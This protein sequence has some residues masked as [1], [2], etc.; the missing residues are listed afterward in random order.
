MLEE[1]H[2]NSKNLFKERIKELIVYQKND[3][4]KKAI[5]IFLS[6]KYEE[7]QYYMFEIYPEFSLNEDPNA[8]LLMSNINIRLNQ[9]DS[10]YDYIRQ[11]I[12]MLKKENYLVYDSLSIIYFLRKDY[13]SAIRTIQELSI[14]NYYYYYHLGLYNQ[15]A[16]FDKMNNSFDDNNI[17]LI[18]NKGTKEEI[19]GYYESAL[20]INANSFKVLLNIGS[21]FASE[22]NFAKAE[23]YFKRALKVN[24]NDWRINLNLAFLNTEKQE[25]LTALDFF[26]KV[27]ALLK[28]KIE[29]RI[30]EPYMFCLYKEKCWQKLEEI[31]KKILKIN[32]KHKRALVLLVEALKYNKKYRQLSNLFDKVKMKMKKVKKD[33]K[34]RTQLFNTHYE[35][36]L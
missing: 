22:E 17:R 31:C 18:E 2:Y 14:T 10:A 30:L 25:Y 23:N 21:I 1:K 4:L 5:Y 16:L 24:P 29:L 12:K 35:S 11:S 9:L 15:A 8:L 6:G 28:D 36:I 13:D 26:E 33:N 34:K 27:I 19:K 20:K 3:I 32:K 7:A